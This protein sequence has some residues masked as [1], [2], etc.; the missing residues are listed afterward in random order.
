MNFF[1]SIIL[2]FFI[3]G[4]ATTQP[5][6]S[7]ITCK[8][9]SWVQNPNID[10]KVGAVGRAMQTLNKKASTQRKVAISRALDEL[11]YKVG[12]DVTLKMQ[13]KYISSNKNLTEN[14]R[15][16]TNY[17]TNTNTTAHIEGAC[18]DRYSNEFFI[19]IVMD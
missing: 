8:N 14:I 11:S 18:I 15:H 10:G 17:Q 9:K 5:N 19:W 6:Q 12:F 7:K 13:G 3:S 4:C 16:N 1:L 2:L